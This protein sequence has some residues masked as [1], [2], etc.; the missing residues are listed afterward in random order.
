MEHTHDR[1]NLKGKKALVTG[2]TKGIGKAILAEFLQLGAEVYM[3]ARNEET[4][5]KVAEEFGGQQPALLSMQADI[6]K[7]ND[8]IKCFE[9][10]KQSWN[11]IDILINNA[12][13]NIRRKMHEYTEEAYNTVLSTNLTSCFH[14]SQLF[15]PLLK[16]S[17]NA[18]VVNISSVAGLT[19]IQ[20][21]AV[22]GMTKAALIQLSRN[23]A[24]EW[25]ADHIRVNA[26]APW[27]IQTPLAAPVLQNESYLQQVL[28]RTPM[29]RIG[30][31]EEVAA[32]VAFLCMPAASYIT[33][34]CLAV[35]GGFSTYGF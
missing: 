25:A 20:T 22:Y 18:S 23:L 13:T 12:G 8:R 1:W 30:N 4:L 10:I 21:G 5:R 19:H 34:Q 27:Y 6:S 7:A 24:A 33:G 15:Y 2:G 9:V 3:V 32:A 28:T 29:R 26:V 17:G 11:G 16:Q 35:D 31:P 14:L